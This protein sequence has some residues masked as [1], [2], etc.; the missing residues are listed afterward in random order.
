MSFLRSK[1][2]ETESGTEK[3]APGGET[4]P[5]QEQLPEKAESKQEKPEQETAPEEAAPKEKVPMTRGAILYKV[6]FVVLAVVIAVLVVANLFAKVPFLN[7][8]LHY[9]SAQGYIEQGNYYRAEQ[10][11]IAALMQDEGY[12]AAHRAMVEL[13]L[14]KGSVADALSYLQNHREQFSQ[15]YYDQQLSLLVPPGT[16]AASREGGEYPEPFA[17]QLT[18]DAYDI[19]YTTDGSDPEP[20]TVGSSLYTPGADISIPYGDTV[21]KAAYAS[22]YGLCGEVL[23][24][25]YHVP[26]PQPEPP[27]LS[28]T[29]GTFQ[30]TM[31]VTV[32]VQEGEVHYTLD[33][34]TPT[35]QSPL[36]EDGV[37]HLPLG[38]QELRVVTINEYGAASEVASGTFWLSDWK[39]GNRSLGGYAA[40]NYDWIFYKNSGDG[41]FYRATKSGT[42][43]E[44]LLRRSV[45][46]I[47]A[48]EDTVYFVDENDSLLYSCATD[49]ANLTAV[50]QSPVSCFQRLEDSTMF[51]VDASSGVLYRTDSSFASPVSVAEDVA[52][53]DALSADQVYILTR[54]GAVGCAAGGSYTQL[55]SGPYKTMLLTRSGDIAALTT[56]GSV[57][58]I[59]SSSG[60]TKRIYS[61]GSD[62]QDTGSWLITT[63][64]IR[65][66]WSALSINAYGDSL[67]FNVRTDSSQYH[68]IGSK[69]E[70]STSYKVMRYDAVSG[71]VTQESGFRANFTPFFTDGLLLSGSEEGVSYANSYD[72]PDV[73]TAASAG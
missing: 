41:L 18:G 62:S 47:Q 51:Y 28:S 11:L 4:V 24:V 73:M 69:T 7:A 17:I 19:Y 48:S 34:T 16:P 45:K 35:Q 46:Y 72:F 38:H 15:S 26:Y 3:T 2:K 64:S 14:E 60:Q 5:E 55:A 43:Q 23:S 6:L 27:V 20:G 49:G 58:L 30:G 63:G 54:Q 22:S 57:D 33:G 61:K 42:D 37:I 31:D 53:F 66:S 10:E 68:I 12:K 1:R 8:R 67:Y 13:Y 50:L 52:F 39:N 40:E 36:C 25:S 32:T 29:G 70:N 59:S 65:S 71:K 56:D 21:V 9:H 44:Q